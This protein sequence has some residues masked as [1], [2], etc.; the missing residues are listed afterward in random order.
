MKNKKW[1]LILLTAL[2]LCFVTSS[3][4]L[5][6]DDEDVDTSGNLSDLIDD[7][8]PVGDFI[9]KLFGKIFDKEYKPFKYMDKAKEKEEG[10]VQLEIKK[11][12][13]ERYMVNNEDTSGIFGFNLYSINNFFMG[14]IQNVVK[15][16][17]SS[18]QLF[19]LNKLDD[20]ADDIESV[21]GSIYEV[22][23]EHFAEILFAFLCGYLVFIFFTKG[24]ARESFRKFMLFVVVLIVAGYWVSNASYLLKSMNALSGE[25]QSTLVSAGD[26]ILGIFDD[27]RE[28]VYAGIN[29]IDENEKIEGTIAVVRNI[30]FDLALKRP[31]LLINYGKTDEK[32]I[33]ADDKIKDLG[34]GFQAFPR[35]ERML[36]FKL[37]SE[38]SAYRI[39]HAHLEV[40]K[41][42]NTNV[43]SGSAFKQSG[44]VF[45]TFFIVIG[46]SIP[47]LLLGLIN[48]A[49]QLLAIFIALALPFAFVLSFIPHFAMTGFKALGNI[50]TI[51][52]TK[53]LLGLLLFVVYLLTYSMYLFVKPVDT[54]MY[55]LH[56]VLLI[57]IFFLIIIK[58]NKI[59]SFV[60]AGR[61]QTVDGNIMPNMNQYYSNQFSNAKK[62]LQE[63]RSQKRESPMN[64]G[65]EK[66]DSKQSAKTNRTSMREERK[67]TENGKG[68]DTK[69]S[70][71]RKKKDDGDKAVPVPLETDDPSKE[72]TSQS[73]N[74]NEKDIGGVNEESRGHAESYHDKEHSVERTS[75]PE[76]T[77]E[78]D[79]SGV[80][81]E[82]RGHAESHHDK[83]RAVE[84]TKQPESI[85]E[86]DVDSVKK[87]NRSHTEVHHDT[88]LNAQRNREVSSVEERK[89]ERDEN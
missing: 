64:Y 89:R 85:N 11:Y 47:F 62:R 31:Y 52:L 22:L 18:L 67:G 9:L 46:L 82:N 61:V 51:F 1:L 87:E 35:S 54:G 83:E 65:D 33:N 58:R 79:I 28:G 20:F 25:I 63:R 78:K 56:V 5:A 55:L 19:T 84:R 17:D 21:S 57:V 23:K 81:E 7:D 88:G 37:N 50:V 13:L 73:E 36:A 6:E 16:T 4:V 10:G 27:K 68:V 40:N 30:Y 15:V 24:N 74:T 80:N 75:Q 69:R 70:P 39:G 2:F 60:T 29:D 86:R 12:P 34:F 53:G 41:N 3:V 44:I 32:E 8:F 71:Q 66:S 48:F 43:A 77:N 38:G 59:I 45:L 14:I 76:N 42:G 26:G 72:R 49:L